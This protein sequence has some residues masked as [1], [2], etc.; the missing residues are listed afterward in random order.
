[1]RKDS[2]FSPAELADFRRKY[3]VQIRVIRGEKSYFRTDKI[4]RYESP[5][6]YAFGHILRRSAATAGGMAHAGTTAVYGDGGHGV[7][8]GRRGYAPGLQR[9]LPSIQTDVSVL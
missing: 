3:Y 2:N 4:V 1:M 5:S 9:L 7:P 8:H 6:T